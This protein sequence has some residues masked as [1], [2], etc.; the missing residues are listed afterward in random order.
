[1]SP[2]EPSEWI[3]KFVDA[4]R[5]GNPEVGK[6][7]FAED[8]TAFGTRTNLAT[9]LAG[10]VSLQ[11]TPIWPSS[12]DFSLQVIKSHPTGDNYYLVLCHFKNFTS[13]NELWIKRAGRATFLLQKRSQS[14]IC[15]HSHFSEMV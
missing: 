10:L 4:V 1:M 9:D 2:R 6:P 11:W 3:A 14:W 13:N 7:L 15:V 12:R 5:T 8:V